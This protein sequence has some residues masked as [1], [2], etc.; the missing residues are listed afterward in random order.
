VFSFI[1]LD[2]GENVVGLGILTG[3][4]YVGVGLGQ[5]PGGIIAARIG[6]KKTAAYGTIIASSACLLC[7][8][9]TGFYQIV[10]LRLVVGLGMSFFFAPG[11]ALIAKYFG[12]REG[13]GVGVFNAMFYFG[14]SLGLF[15]W[16]IFANDFGWR[17]SLV[18]S[19]TLG[20]VTALMILWFLPKDDLREKSPIKGSA[21]MRVLTDRWL[22]LLGLELFG[23]G[24]GASLITGIMVYYLEGSLRVNP[25]LAGL[26]GGISPVVALAASPLAGR[27]YDNNKNASKLLFLSGVVMG[28]GLAFA[29]IP[30]IYGAILSATVVGFCNG[31]GSTVAY[32]AAREAKVARGEYESLAVGWV[33]SLNL[34]AGFFSPVLFSFIVFHSGY[35]TAWLIAGVYTTLLVSSALIWRFFWRFVRYTTY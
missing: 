14:G 31:A 16:A 7:G 30:T 28:I 29:S 32:S 33:N 1:A 3:S 20:F 2:F 5:V 35:M 26:I 10:L 27:G 23:I 24:C 13:L 25:A 12:R 22:I 18:T 9:A 21:L 34:Y 11:V 17:P 15:G 19:G 8:L 4:F 6:P